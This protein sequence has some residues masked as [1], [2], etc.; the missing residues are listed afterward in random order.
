MKFYETLYIVHPALEAGRL[1]DIII[2]IENVLKNN[3]GKIISTDIWGKK[4]LAYMIDK[5]K[6]GT[7]VL[8][9][10][11]SDGSKNAQFNI[12]L[13]HNPNVLRYLTTTI[14]EEDVDTKSVSIDEQLNPANVPNSKISNEN[15]ST[16]TTTDVGADASSE[17]TEESTATDVGADASSEPTEESTTTDVGADASSDRIGKQIDNEEE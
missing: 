15:I 12:N 7:Y 2:D 10:F 11:K 6:Y 8:I 4:K 3:N 13:E 17:P 14:D 9:Q 5:Q 16:S 1:K